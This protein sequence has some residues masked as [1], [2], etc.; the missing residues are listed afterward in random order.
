M[1][2][3][4]ARAAGLADPRITSDVKHVEIGLTDKS[5]SAR[6]AARW[7]AE[8][9]ITGRLILVGGDEFGPVGDVPGSDSY[10]LVPEL[11]RAIVVSVGVEPGVPP[12]VVH[13][14]GGPAQFLGLLDA[15]LARRRD[16]R[17]PAID[18]DPAWVRDALR[19]SRRWSAPRRR[20]ARSPT[21]GS[22]SGEPARR[23]DRARCR[24]SRPTGIY[25][26]GPAPRLLPGPVWT[27]LTVR[28]DGR[29]ERLVDLRTG[30]LVRTSRGRVAAS[31]L[32]V[33]VGRA[34]RGV[35]LAGR[36]SGRPTW[37]LGARSR[38]PTTPLAWS[39]S[40]RGAVRLAAP[41]TRPV[42]GSR[43]RPATGSR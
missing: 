42:A 8:R 19:S 37:S 16:R 30:V 11:A 13:A 24:C 34:P 20:S 36:G 14:A 5:D 22:A 43:S 31:H 26:S 12:G 1:A 21:V 38:H 35:G 39:A 32:A 3:A 2:T 23:T 10:L 15:Q 33:R 29:D 7:L 9:G 4:A 40:D 28:S 27:D 18:D 25:T 17:V 41:Q 6:W